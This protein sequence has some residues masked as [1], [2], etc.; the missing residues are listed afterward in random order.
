MKRRVKSTSSLIVRSGLR[1]PNNASQTSNHSFP[2]T[3]LEEIVH[4]HRRD[5]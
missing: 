3:N 4:G 2:D 5:F 1:L